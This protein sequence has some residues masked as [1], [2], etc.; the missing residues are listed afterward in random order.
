MTEVATFQMPSALRRLFAT[1]LVFCEATEIRRLWDKHLPSMS[2]DYR[3]TQSNEA[4]LEQMVLRDIRDM[5]QSMG[6]DIKSYGLP[7]IVETD[8]SSD[9]EYREVAEEMQI[10]ANQ[11]HLDLISC[12]NSEQ[13]AGFN[14]IMDHVT[15]QKSKI[16]FVD[17]PGGTGKTYMYKALLAKVRSMGQIAI[18]TAT[19]GIAASIM[20]GGRTAHSRF[21]IPIK[22]SDNSMCGF[23]KQSGTAKLLKQASLIIWDEVAMTKRQAVETLD[24]TD[25]KSVV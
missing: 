20:P 11:E 1:I 23:T 24:R 13:L 6:K 2:E 7:D 8:C 15:N 25:R 12:L 18:A 9:T 5:L 10:I 19:S 14:E 21:K 3:R 22:L 17:G 16:F 4:T